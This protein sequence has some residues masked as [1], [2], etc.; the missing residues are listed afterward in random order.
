M[1]PGGNHRS[2]TG[3]IFIHKPGAKNGKKIWLEELDD[4]IADGWVKGRIPRDP[5]V[6]RKTAESNRGKKY[7]HSENYL[8][9]GHGNAGRP[10]SE[11]HRKVL[12]KRKL[13]RHWISNDTLKL[14]KMVPNDQVEKYLSEGWIRGRNNY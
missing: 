11:E 1:V 4:Y 6:V 13:G 3:M 14:T 7:N 8:K 2:V 9:N 12:S 5:E 10:L